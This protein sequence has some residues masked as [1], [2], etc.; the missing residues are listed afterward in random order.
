MSKHGSSGEKIKLNMSKQRSYL[1]NGSVI[2]T[3]LIGL[4]FIGH[5]G[6]RNAIY[7]VIFSAMQSHPFQEK[8]RK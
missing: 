2:N 3:T 4:N 1:K 8:K 6:V 5:K 7:P